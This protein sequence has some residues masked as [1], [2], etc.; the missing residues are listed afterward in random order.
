MPWEEMYHSSILIQKEQFGFFLTD[1][2]NQHKQD[3]WIPSSQ[4][5]LF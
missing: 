5:L 4:V 2:Q 3:L 1:L